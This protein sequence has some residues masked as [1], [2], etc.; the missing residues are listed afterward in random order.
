MK[1]LLDTCTFLWLIT[2]DPA[3][4]QHSRALF[5]SPDNTVYLSAVSVWEMSVKYSIGKLDF[6]TSPEQFIPNQRNRHD[7]LSLSLEESATLHLHKLPL[8][9][10]DPFDRMLICQAIYHE[11]TLLTPDSLINQYAVR[12]AW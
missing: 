7:I 3:L 1:L 12:T 9:H 5:A 6:H 11:M 2:D 8:F 10:R 4:S